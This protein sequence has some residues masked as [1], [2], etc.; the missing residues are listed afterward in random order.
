MKPLTVGTRV[1]FPASPG[2]PEGYGELIVVDGER[3]VVRADPPLAEGDAG[4]REVHVTAL[5][6]VRSITRHRK[7]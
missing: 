1:W 7:E 3:C 4:M 5:R 6:R 2:L